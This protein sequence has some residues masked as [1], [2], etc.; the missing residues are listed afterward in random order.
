M[1]FKNIFCRISI[2]SKKEERKWG[3]VIELSTFCLR[4]CLRAVCEAIPSATN[5]GRCCCIIDCR[6]ILLTSA[7]VLEYSGCCAV[8]VE[9]SA[10]TNGGGSSGILSVAVEVWLVDGRLRGCGC[11]YECAYEH[12]RKHDHP[13][14]WDHRSVVW[15][16]LAIRN[17]AIQDSYTL[18]ANGNDNCCW[19]RI[20]HSAIGS[21]FHNFVNIHSPL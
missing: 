13:C 18:N 5:V 8:G 15:L 14:C 9:S 17:P 20:L 4:Y 16:V 3:R 19:V 7:C 12:G 21:F 2:A 6:Y 11:W 10:S 1:E